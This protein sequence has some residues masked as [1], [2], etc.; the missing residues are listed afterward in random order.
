MEDIKVIYIYDRIN[1]ILQKLCSQ[2]IFQFLYRQKWC[3]KCNCEAAD[4]MRCKFPENFEPKYTL[5]QIR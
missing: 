5:E 4:N 2:T 3:T 1:K